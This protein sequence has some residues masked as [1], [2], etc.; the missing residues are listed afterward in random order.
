MYRV[1]VDFCDQAGKIEHRGFRNI[2]DAQ[3]VARQD[4]S[5]FKHARRA[6]VFGPDGSATVEYT[7]VACACGQDDAA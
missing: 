6:T 4:L 7:Q 5:K 2:S 3:G 1:A